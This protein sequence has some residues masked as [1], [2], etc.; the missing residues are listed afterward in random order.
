ME[1]N[2]IPLAIESK[3]PKNKP[4]KFMAHRW[5]KEEPTNFTRVTKEVE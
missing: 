5:E 2:L 1:G 3:I 4:K